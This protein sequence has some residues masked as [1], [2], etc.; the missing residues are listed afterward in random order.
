MIDKK[1]SEVI[2]KLGLLPVV[3]L[4]GYDKKPNVAWSIEQNIINDIN[5]VNSV[6]ANNTY[7]YTTREGATKKL[8]WR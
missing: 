4:S 8:F 5:S 2:E 6:L 7:T 3:P 1:I